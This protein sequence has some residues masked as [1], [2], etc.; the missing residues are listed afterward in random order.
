MMTQEQMIRNFCVMNDGEID[1]FLEAGASVQSGI[2]TGGGFVWNFK[3]EI[4]CTENNISIK[5]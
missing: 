2:P 3:R 4:Y 5:I 1:F